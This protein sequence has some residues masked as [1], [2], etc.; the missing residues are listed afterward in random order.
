MNHGLSLSPIQLTRR[1]NKVKQILDVM[2]TSVVN[3]DAKF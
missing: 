2:V 1:G 3:R